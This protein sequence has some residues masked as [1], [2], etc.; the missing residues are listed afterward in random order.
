VKFISSFV[1]SIRKYK[2]RR[3]DI[4]KAEIRPINF[5]TNPLSNLAE[6]AW[7][8]SE[9]NRENCGTESYA[10]MLFKWMHNPVMQVP[11]VV[12]NGVYGS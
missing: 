7:E 2:K 11:E 3:I 4:N 6:T 5:G 10:K 1:Q 12:G 9:M 8:V